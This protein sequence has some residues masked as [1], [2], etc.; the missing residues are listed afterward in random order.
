MRP[1]ERARPRGR[2]STAHPR[3]AENGHP[4]GTPAAATPQAL[5]VG[6]ETVLMP[7]DDHRGRTLRWIA[8]RRPRYM[9]WLAGLAIRNPRLRRA[10][11][12]ASAMGVLDLPEDR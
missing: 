4:Q 12:R 9:T 3:V 5:S 10:I 6:W 7:W 2:A 11:V 8:G 1:T